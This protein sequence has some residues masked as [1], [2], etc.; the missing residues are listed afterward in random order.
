MY[1]EISIDGNALTDWK[2]FHSVF[3]QTL[4]FPEYYADNIDAW[5]ECMVEIK[6]SLLIT[7]TDSEILKENSEEIYFTILEC[8]ALVNSIKLDEG[9][10]SVFAVALD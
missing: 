7:I 2:A 10:E 9:D 4:N 3:K 1:K 5:I 6:E 8:V